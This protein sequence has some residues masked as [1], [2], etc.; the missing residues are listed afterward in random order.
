VFM[1]VDHLSVSDVNVMSSRTT[2]E[3]E[4]T[5]HAGQQIDDIYFQYNHKIHRKFCVG[6]LRTGPFLDS[7]RPPDPF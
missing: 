4:F 3:F 1:V 2:K 6:Q 7:D 5:M